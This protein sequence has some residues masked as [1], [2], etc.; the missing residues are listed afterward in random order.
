M[1]R[2]RRVPS[3]LPAA[4]QPFYFGHR[5]RREAGQVI[6]EIMDAEGE[7]HRILRVPLGRVI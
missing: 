2:P 3:P 4:A 1:P 7:V 6:Y 5:V